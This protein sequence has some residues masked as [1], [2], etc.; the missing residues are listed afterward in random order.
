MSGTFWSSWL[1]TAYDIITRA[2]ESLYTQYTKAFGRHLSYNDYTVAWICAL[3]V[4]M[5]AAQVLL[6]EVHEDLVADPRDHNTYVLG[7]IGKH[8]VAIAGLPSGGYGLISAAAVAIHLV[9]SFPAIRIGL[10]VGI[11]GGVPSKNADI[12]LGD[13]VISKPTD[14]HGGVVQY[15][16]IE[17]MSDGQFV[18]MGMSD[19]PPSI[20]LSTITR[21]QYMH[22]AY[23]RH[24]MDHLA[25]MQEKL[26]EYAEGFARP[27]QED[28]LYLADYKH[29]DPRSTNCDT[30]D[31]RATVSRRP[32]NH[33]GPGFHYGTIAS[34]NTLVK[35]SKPRDALAKELGAKCVEMEAAGLMNIFPSLVI[36]GICDYADSHKN[37]KWQGFAAAVAAAY[38]KE[39]LLATPS[40]DGKND[41]ELLSNE[42]GRNHIGH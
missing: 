8:N 41:L 2:C 40:S 42:S 22:F 3:P 7:R 12:R 37:D 4:E 23:E 1:F 11:G 10:M 27:T 32:R 39:L 28:R 17:A 38:A 33:N 20:L 14:E 26:G 30:C 35:D 19:R 21:M 29:V 36:R 18:R 13:V 24:V 16:F 9:R 5:A 31:P 15:D 34:A 6:D 25:A